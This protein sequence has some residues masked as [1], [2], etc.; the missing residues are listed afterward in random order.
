MVNAVDALPHNL[1]F[2][3]S[4]AAQAPGPLSASS[5]KGSQLH[6]FQVSLPEGSS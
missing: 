5:L 1:A 2:V 4:S 6:L 3:C